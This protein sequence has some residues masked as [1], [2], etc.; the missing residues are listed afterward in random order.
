MIRAL[1]CEIQAAAAVAA[2][3]HSTLIREDEAPGQSEGQPG[4][5]SATPLA[6][7]LEAE[8]VT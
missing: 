6:L 8:A 7:L 2:D 4:S 1:A 5:G 3:A